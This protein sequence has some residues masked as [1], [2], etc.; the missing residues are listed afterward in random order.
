MDS[1]DSLFPEAEEQWRV[2]DLYRA[3]G[4]VKG[5]EKRPNLNSTEKALLRGLLCLVHPNDIAIALNWKTSSVKTEL[6]T[7]IYQYVKNFT[8]HLTQRIRW[9]NVSEW[10]EE[11]GYKLVRSPTAENLFLAISQENEYISAAEVIQIVENQIVEQQV[12]ENQLSHSGNMISRTSF[13]EIQEVGDTYFEK[14][15]YASAMDVYTTLVKQYAVEYPGLLLKI[16]QIYNCVECYRDS[17]MLTYFALNYIK[18]NYAKGKLY[19]LLAIAFDELCRRNPNPGIL[20]Q[21]LNFYR[22]A[23]D[24][25]EQSNAVVLWNKFDLIVNFINANQAH[26]VQHI[27]MAKIAWI[28]FRET[29]THEASNFKDYVQEIIAD[30]ENVVSGGIEDPWLSVEINNFISQLS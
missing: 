2:N 8:G 4:K 30:M 15:N 27:N 23:S 14:G 10:L 19:H 1:V 21:A 16:A 26:Y 6:S 18:D 28:E 29:T 17:V 24:L 7:T 12:L 3:L 20:R 13:Q 25:S 5:G 22:E 9:H 11:A